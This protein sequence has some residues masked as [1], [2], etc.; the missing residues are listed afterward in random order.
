MEGLDAS[1]AAIPRGSNSSSG[2]AAIMEGLLIRL[3]AVKGSWSGE[4]ERTWAEIAEFGFGRGLG[5]G[6]Q[7]V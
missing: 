3:R 1:H 2:I 6:S 4:V 5:Y 7:D